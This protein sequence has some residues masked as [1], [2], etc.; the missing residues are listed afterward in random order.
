MRRVAGAT[1]TPDRQLLYSLV[2]WRPGRRLTTKPLQRHRRVFS[3]PRRIKIALFPIV[4][5][6][7]SYNSI[8]IYLSHDRAAPFLRYLWLSISQL[9]LVCKR[10]FVTLGRRDSD[11]EPIHWGIVTGTFC[12]Q[13]VPLSVQ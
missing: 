8:I 12:P 7:D 5:Q 11:E 1:P 2:L 9:V 13:G 4:T 10:D 3:E 6:I